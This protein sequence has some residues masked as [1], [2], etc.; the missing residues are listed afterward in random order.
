M[1][2]Y[3]LVE[4]SKTEPA[5]YPKILSIFCPKYTEVKSVNEITQNCY[6]IFAG[7][8]Y[9]NVV[10]S[11]LLEAVKQVCYL[12]TQTNIKID[13]LVIVVDVDRFRTINRLNQSVTDHLRPYSDK[14]QE[15]HIDVH[16]VIQNRCIESWFLGNRKI[17]PVTYSD[18]FAQFA[19]YYNVSLLNPED[20][21]SP[22]KSSDSQYAS[23]Y[24]S[25]MLRQNN[26]KYNKNYIDDIITEEYVKE[27]YNR[28]K[29]GD[30]KSFR[31]FLDLVENMNNNLL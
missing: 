7:F 20:M 31:T 14:L 9:P 27:V 16:L 28:Y 2:Y 24:L 13:K 17:F 21:T 18:Y 6:Y 26:K 22:D 19:N 8:G 29:D 11:K 3:F 30:L 10:K 4:G 23:K 5:L 12:N 1:N 15:A 25:E